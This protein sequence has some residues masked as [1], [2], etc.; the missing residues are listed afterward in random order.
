MRNATSV[1]HITATTSWL[2][3]VGAVHKGITTV[4]PFSQILTTTQGSYYFTEFIF[5]FFSRQNE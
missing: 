4:A 2:L 5:P 3:Q 1:I